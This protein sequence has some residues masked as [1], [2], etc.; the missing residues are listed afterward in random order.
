L[1][2]ATGLEKRVI[3]LGMGKRF[4]IWNEDTY[5]EKREEESNLDEQASAEMS[6]LVL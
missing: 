4:E 3:M 6:R 5:L 2:Q 1:R